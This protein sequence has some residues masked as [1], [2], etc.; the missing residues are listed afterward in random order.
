MAVT[1]RSLAAVAAPPCP[2]C[3]DLDGSV[4]RTDLLLE[5]LLLLLKRNPLYLL[6]MLLWLARGRA[7]LKA[8][9]ARRVQLDPAA[10]PY[11]TEL[12]AWL[13]RERAQGR[14]LW[15]CTGANERLA[16][17]VAQYLGLFEGVIASDATHNLTGR[18]KAER[19]VQSFGFRAF[20][21]CGNERRDLAIWHCSNGAIVVSH[22]AA[23]GMRVA[24]RVPLLQTFSSGGH[25][26][27]AALRALRPHQWAKN[28][29]LFVPL[30]AAHRAGDLAAFGEVVLAYVAF[31]LCASSVYVL[32]DML[33][34]PSDRAHARKS[35]RP[36]ASG[37]LPL[38]AGFFLVPALLVTAIAVA[39]ALP[40]PFLLVLAGYYALT[41]AYSITLKGMI[42]VDA[43]ALAGLY[44]L[45]IVAGAAAT[46]VVP[47]FWLLLFSVFLFLSLAIVKRYAELDSLRRRG[48]LQAAGRDYDIGDLPMLESVGISAGYVSV[49]VLA[50]YVNSPSTLLLYRRPEV[51]W[52]LCVLLLYWITRIWMKTHRGKMHDD[53]VLFAMRDRVSLATGLFAAFVVGLAV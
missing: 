39:G 48:Q 46:G 3:V 2:L 43:I 37:D 25:R 1:E 41:T 31:C 23:L 38:R 8:E 5:S 17:S 45:R 15:L 35:K 9:I 11:N 28:V 40:V 33:D 42:F 19:L 6:R 51:L 27:R 29:L 13:R 26:F 20:D 7:V 49:L 52:G 16:N 14:Q 34:L 30:L 12:L 50:L 36:F 44:T 47:S 53:P 4:V 22:G 18:R 24:S 32:N 10:L 21:Y